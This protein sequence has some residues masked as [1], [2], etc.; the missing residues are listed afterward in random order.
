MALTLFHS[1]LKLFAPKHN[2]L[3]RM[4]KLLDQSSKLFASTTGDICSAPLPRRKSRK[5]EK[6][7]GSKKAKNFRTEIQEERD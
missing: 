3:A 6:G 2:L 1:I 7:A 5:V 4:S